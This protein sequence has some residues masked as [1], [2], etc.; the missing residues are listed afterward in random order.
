MAPYAS[1]DPTVQ[2]TKD[3]GPAAKKGAVLLSA[4]AIEPAE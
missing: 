4:R 1:P 2:Q 3:R